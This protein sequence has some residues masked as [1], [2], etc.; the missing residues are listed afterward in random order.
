MNVG[1]AADWY[2]FGHYVYSAMNGHKLMSEKAK[3]P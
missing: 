2:I 1:F 3:K